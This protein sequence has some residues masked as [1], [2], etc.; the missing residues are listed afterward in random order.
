MPLKHWRIDRF[1]PMKIGR[2]LDYCP[3]GT[4]RNFEVLAEIRPVKEAEQIVD[5]LVMAPE[6]LEAAKEFLQAAYDEKVIPI[7]ME[8]NPLTKA[9]LRL[10]KAI[11]RSEGKGLTYGE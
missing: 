5:I 3:P 9:S 10:T 4:Q 6:V 11:L 2:G 7:V 1:N 8:D